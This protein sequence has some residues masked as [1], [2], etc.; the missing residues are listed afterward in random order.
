MTTIELIDQ[1]EQIKLLADPRRLEIVR[2]LLAGSASL[3]QLGSKLEQ[4]PARVRHHL[5]KLEQAGLVELDEIT[6]TKG[7]TEKFYRAKAGAYLFQKMVL[8][9]DSERK[10]IIFSGSHDLAVDMLS[11]SLGKE[12]NVL[13]LSN[14][15]LDGLIALRQGFSH[16]SGSHLMDMDG[17]YNTAH[18]RNLLSDHEPDHHYPGKPAAGIDDGN[19][20]SE[21]NSRIG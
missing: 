3:T 6:I 5:Q 21:R 1:F 18:V 4:H 12:I 15:S 9:N 16:I 10:T 7:I 17:E 13:N 8:P 14:G 11:Q 19:R 20:E 2:L